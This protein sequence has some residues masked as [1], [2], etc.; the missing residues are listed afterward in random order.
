MSKRRHSIQLLI[1]ALITSICVSEALIMLFLSRFNSLSPLVAAAIDVSLLLALVVPV[2]LLVVYKPMNFYFDQ[3]L[4]SENMVKKDEQLILAD[5]IKR[6]ELI[7]ELEHVTTK[8]SERENQMLALL[9]ALA[10][11]K[12]FNTGG[13]VIRTQKYVTLLAHRLQSMGHFLE[14]LSNQKIETLSKVAPLHDI[15][16][17]GVPDAILQKTGKL[18]NEERQVIETH[19]LIGESI[20]YAAD[21]K[22]MSDEDL[23]TT[24]IKVAGGH[25]ER[26]D[27]AGYPRGL[28]GEAI[29]IEARIMA[30]ADVYD[31]LISSR[32]YKRHWTHQEA[33]AEI[34]SKKGMHF[35]PLVVDAFLLEEGNFMRVAAEFT[36]LVHKY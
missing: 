8:V 21:F 7:Q 9:N 5:A 1:L 4:A 2:V 19:P 16:K 20:L 29:P 12:D 28:V 34:H 26:W 3:L 11:A 10:L 36:Q 18:T 27:G 17:M 25:H 15:G 33:V 30:L 13:H 32:S 35:D 6:D 31:A 14:S 24:A 23:M 22:E